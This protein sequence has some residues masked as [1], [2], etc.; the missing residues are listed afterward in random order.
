MDYVFSNI[1]LFRSSECR[2]SANI[3][4]RGAGECY[5]AHYF[6]RGRP[7]GP[8]ES[9]QRMGDLDPFFLGPGF[10]YFL[11]AKP[12]KGW[13]FWAP[14]LV[15]LQNPRYLKLTT[16][17]SKSR[18]ADHLTSKWSENRIKGIYRNIL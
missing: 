2:V 18:P 10:G 4:D 7:A 1:D 15:T 11:L 14:I 16:P 12:H 9:P 5:S 6:F 3:H 13:P 17:F 8:S